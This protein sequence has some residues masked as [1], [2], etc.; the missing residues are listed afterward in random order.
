MENHGQDRRKFL[1]RA[2][3]AATAAPAVATLITAT[4]KPALAGGHYGSGGPQGNNGWGNGPDGENPGSF[5]G[6]GVSQ[7][8][9]GG[10]MAQDKSKPN[11]GGR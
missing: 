1:K 2:G 3:T 7:G 6:G 5:H 8:G 9:P 10:G 11:G 4:S